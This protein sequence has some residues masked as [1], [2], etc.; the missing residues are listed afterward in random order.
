MLRHYLSFDRRA[1][2]PGVPFCADKPVRQVIK[3]RFAAILN[4]PPVTTTRVGIELEF[5]LCTL[6]G[7]PILA[8]DAVLAHLADRL[9]LD[10]IQW[11]D[12]AE[13][14][15]ARTSDGTATIGYEYARSLLEFTFT[16]ARDCTALADKLQRLLPAVDDALADIGIYLGQTGLHPQKWSRSTSP[17]P[18]PHYMAVDR[19]LRSFGK[20]ADSRTFTGFIA[21]SQTH[22]DACAVSTPV[23]LDLY[24]RSAFVAA[25]LLANSPASMSGKQHQIARDHLWITSAFGKLGGY[26]EQPTAT[27]MQQV[28]ETEARRGLFLAR[29]GDMIWTFDP[30]ALAD[31][32]SY[33]VVRATTDRAGRTLTRS[34]ELTPEDAQLY[35]AY[36]FAVPTAYGTVEVRSDCLQPRDMLMAPA[37][38]AVGLSATADR[39]IAYLKSVT[40]PVPPAQMRADAARN[41]WAMRPDGLHRPLS[42]ICQTVLE[43][44]AQGLDLRRFDER[45]FLKPL[46]DRAAY[47]ARRAQPQQQEA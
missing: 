23:L 33:P 27:T 46:F 29:R 13:A 38:F 25:L 26:T 10:I 1:L 17:L 8:A 16:P 35:R 39:V 28:L 45:R 32:D 36:G 41:G 14:I 24:Q 22:I 2:H 7:R 40:G 34:L 6:T 47:H 44:A 3:D 4:R 19:F 5:P 31:L 42:E 15:A 43:Y 18:T 9:S 21:S 11:A 37:A 30:I 12:N 20:T